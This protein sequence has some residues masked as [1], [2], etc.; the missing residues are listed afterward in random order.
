MFAKAGFQVSMYDVNQVQISNA[1]ETC[2]TQLKKMEDD[3]IL[4]NKKVSSEEIFSLITGSSNL[5]EALR[6]AC[7][8]QV[9]H[10]LIY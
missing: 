2:R 3:G 9:V 6:N 10:Q 8:V 5:S 4:E 1:L 7:Y